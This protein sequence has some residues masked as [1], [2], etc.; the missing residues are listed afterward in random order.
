MSDATGGR[1]C[2]PGLKPTCRSAAGEEVCPAPLA[3]VVV[4][5]VS[6]VGAEEGREVSKIKNHALKL[7]LK[8]IAARVL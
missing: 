1:K 5:N 2:S 7:Q 8:S 4:R 3:Q 6:D